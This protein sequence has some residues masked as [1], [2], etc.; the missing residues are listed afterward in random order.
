MGTDINFN[1]SL[2]RTYGT[3]IGLPAFDPAAQA[4]FTAT[5]ITG[6]TQQTAINNLIKGLKS[7]GIWSKM[8]AVYPFVTDNRNRLS[9]TEDFTNN[10]WTKNAISIT[11]NTTTAPDGTT[12]ADTL[13]DGL[14]NNAHYINTPVSLG[15]NGNNTLS[16]Y[17][18][19]NTLNFLWIYFYN[20]VEPAGPAAWFNLS[21]GTIGTV[22]SGITANIE[23]AGNGWYRCSITRNFNFTASFSNC[24]FGV[25]NADNVVSY[26]GTNKSLFVWGPQLDA[27]LTP[28]TYQPIATT[29]QAFIAS[30]FKFN[31]KDPRDLDAAFRL[32]FNGGW[33][34]SSNGALPNGTNGY[35]DTKLI[36]NTNLTLNS[37]SFSVYSR[38]NFTPAANQSYGVYS[39]GTA[40]PLIGGTFFVD[41]SVSGL[42]YSYLPPD[43]L[44]SSTGQNLA[45]MFLTTRTSA[46]NAKLFRNTTQLAAVTTQGQTSQPITSFLF[47]AFRN[48]GGVQDYNSFQYAF[49]H[50]ADGLTDTEAS[51]LYTRVQTFNQALGRQVGVPIVSDADAQAFLNSAEIT[52]LTQANA[53]NTLVT[54]LK[55]QGLWTKMKAIYPFV[56][57][58][59]STHKWNLKDPRDLD[60]AYRLVFNGGWTHSSNGATPNGTNGYADTKLVPNS[61][62]TLNN[63]HLSFYSRTNNT[64]GIDDLSTVIVGDT[65]N[66]RVLINS[67]GSFITEINSVNQRVTIANANS[68]GFYQVSRTSATSLNIYKNAITFGNNTNTNTGTQPITSMYLGAANR[69]GSAI[70]YSNRECA[71]ASL[72]DGLTNTEAAALYTAVQTYQTTLNRQ[73]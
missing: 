40:L 5:G 48:Q 17:A 11:A 59:A 12:T 60:A 50:I 6:V 63:A 26:L 25:S 38:N 34:H 72:G 29:Q 23:N 53:I 61:A 32:V 22:Y 62:L 64:T 15:I 55:A 33:T 30:Q 46:S 27:G 31:L 16:I 57:G 7:D 39:S 70:N 14:T 71:F 36:P 66:M 2:G 35:A 4:Y 13:S 18:K 69:L 51:N 10:F 20:G 73:V 19:A 68:L 9:Y 44:L 67:A 49:A 47:G 65:Q 58:T 1:K 45:A 24:G 42:T 54:D 41:K 43:V 3:Y 21:N 52:D 28:T 8:K 56:G 37:C